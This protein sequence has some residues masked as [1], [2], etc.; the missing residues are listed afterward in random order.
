MISQGL[1]QALLHRSQG[2]APVAAQANGKG[3]CHWHG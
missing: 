1:L 2:R 3:K